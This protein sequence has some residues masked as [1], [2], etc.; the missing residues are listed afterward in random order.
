M[1]VEA[2]I[3]RKNERVRAAW[4]TPLRTPALIVLGDSDGALLP[5]LLIKIGD[6]LPHSECHVLPR[7]S[8][9]AQQ[10]APEDVNRLLLDFLS[11]DSLADAQAVS[12][13][14]KSG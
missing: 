13:A 2:M 10:D 12:H 3:F 9:W 5:N 1:M 6:L 8:H 11:G 14:C 4:R 7:C